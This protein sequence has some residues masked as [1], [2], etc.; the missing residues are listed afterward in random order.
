MR[1]QLVLSTL[2]TTTLAANKCFWDVYGT[3]QT[4]EAG[5]SIKINGVG[6]ACGT[7]SSPTFGVFAKCKVAYDQK[8]GTCDTY[9]FG[10]STDT[11]KCVYKKSGTPNYGTCKEIST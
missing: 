3:T 11:I 6:I 7:T 4:I 10:K 5:D 8:V 2:L 1:F 9:A